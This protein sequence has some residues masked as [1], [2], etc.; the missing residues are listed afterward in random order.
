M[1][2]PLRDSYDRFFARFG[3]RVPDLIA[4]GL[5][6]TVLPA[7]EAIDRSWAAAQKRFEKR[8]PH[9]IRSFG[10]NGQGT[11]LYG[12]FYRLLVSLGVQPDPTNNH[13]PWRVLSEITENG[14]AHLRN[15]QISHVF[16]CTKN[17]ILFTAPWNIVWKPKVLDPFAG[18]EAKGDLS[19]AYKVA[20]YAFIRETYARYLQ[21]YEKLRAE[22]FQPLR[23]AD[24]VR[25]MR[26]TGIFAS[27]DERRR[28][29]TSLDRE[30]GPL[31]PAALES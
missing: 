17:P 10:R 6:E 12:V 24:V 19:D 30:L 3:I 5:E 29:L 4:F 25:T 13:W 18:H 7:G 15:Y 1:A 27:D 14:G 11:H 2:R 20:F 31:E 8:E 23:V 22:A 28:F 21:E 16:G 9:W 26:T